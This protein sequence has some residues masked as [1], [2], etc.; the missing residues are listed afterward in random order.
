MKNNWKHLN[1][2]NSK[3]TNYSKKYKKKIKIWINMKIYKNILSQIKRLWIKIWIIFKSMIIITII[4][5]EKLKEKRKSNKI[6]CK[7]II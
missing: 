7:W 2:P 3:Q 4:Q 1:L 6:T 5:L